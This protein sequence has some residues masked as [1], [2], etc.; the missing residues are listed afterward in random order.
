MSCIP[1]PDYNFTGEK[2]YLST[3]S[4]MKIFHDSIR[5]SGAIPELP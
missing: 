2:I 3:R 4:T 5:A 1:Y